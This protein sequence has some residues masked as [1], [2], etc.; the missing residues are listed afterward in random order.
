MQSNSEVL[1]SV[2]SVR[3]RSDEPEGKPGIEEDDVG[4]DL[5]RER[6]DPSC[7]R[8]RREQPRLASALDAERLAGVPLGRTLVRR[9]EHRGLGRRQTP[10]QLV[11]HRLDPADLGREVV[12]DEE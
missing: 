8:P 10:P 12:R 11:E 9:G 1:V 2:Y 6:V 3:K 5:A 4:T 7:Q